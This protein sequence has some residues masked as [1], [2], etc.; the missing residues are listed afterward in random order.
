[1][2]VARYNRRGENALDFEQIKTGKDNITE[3][4]E[5]VIDRIAKVKA[6]Q[7]SE[8]NNLLYQH[9]QELLKYAKNKNESNKVGFFWDLNLYEKEP[10]KIKGTK[11]GINMNDNSDVKGLVVSRHIMSVV[12]MMAQSIC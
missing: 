11:N 4:D 5:D 9:H 3:I 8:I 2:P 7:E 10:L 6:F 12:V 1:M